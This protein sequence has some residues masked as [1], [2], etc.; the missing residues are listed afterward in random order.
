MLS[1]IP[2]VSK[3]DC[4]HVLNHMPFA[5]QGDE[6]NII[7]IWSNGTCVG[8]VG[9]KYTDGKPCLSFELDY[10]GEIDK[11]KLMRDIF[12]YYFTIYPHIYAI[13][14]ISNYKPY[15]ACRQMGF[16]VIYTSASQWTMVLDAASWRYYK[17]WPL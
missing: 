17:K 4:E 15:K 16:K 3:A 7:G 8:G 1:V 10:R 2:A 14:D 12:R 6:L 13:I 5:A 9:I 11:V